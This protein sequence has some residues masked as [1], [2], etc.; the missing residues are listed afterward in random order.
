MAVVRLEGSTEVKTGV[1]TDSPTELE[2]PAAQRPLLEEQP[3]GT[4]LV[5]G[6]SSISS[7]ST[8]SS[9]EISGQSG[10]DAASGGGAG[11]W[12]HSPVLLDDALG[13]A[14]SELGKVQHI[15]S[16]NFEHVK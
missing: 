16:P 13:A 5:R 11:L 6:S 1:N 14:L 8:S 15:V 12:V 2:V 7:K 4:V 9:G 3:D 10:S